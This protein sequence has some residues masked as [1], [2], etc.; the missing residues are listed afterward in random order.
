MAKY[1]KSHSNYRLTQKHQDVNNG[2]ILERDISTIGGVDSF[3]TGQTPIYQSGNFVITVN[4]TITATKHIVKKGWQQNSES[5][6]T[7]NKQI[8]ENYASDVNGSVES[9]IA[10]KNDFADLRS[11]A[12]YGSLY[13]LVETSISDIIQKYPY[14]IYIPKRDISERIT[15]LLDGHS[16]FELSN[17][18]LI[19]FYTENPTNYDDSNELHYLLNGGYKNYEV[20]DSNDNRYDLS[21]LSV[22]SAKLSDIVVS[23]SVDVR[24]NILTLPDSS[25]I[26]NSTYF[27]ITES[28]TTFTSIVWN[29]TKYSVKFYN[30][31][32]NNFKLGGKYFLRYINGSFIVLD[33]MCQE[34]G[35][36]L[37]SV[38]LMYNNGK[39]LINLYA[40]A[41]KNVGVKSYSETYNEELHIRPKE[42]EGFYDEFLDGMNQFQKC[43]L[44]EYSNT[45]FVANFEILTETDSGLRKST[46][47][48][49]LPTDDGGYNIDSS[50]IA[51]ESYVKRLAK[52]ALRYDE[53]FTDNMY[54]LM[55]HESLK[56]F[57]WTRNFNG[58]DN[59]TDN[60]YVD[61][62]EKF[63]SIIRIIGFAF[64]NEKSYID[65][66][67]NVNSISYD[68]R[69]NIPDYFLTDALSLDGWETTTIYPFELKFTD[70]EGN[71]V[72][73]NKDASIGSDERYQWD[74]LQT[75]NTYTRSFYENNQDIIYPYS[76]SE[77]EFYQACVNGKPTLLSVPED[78]DSSEYYVENGSVKNIIKDYS[79]QTEYTIPNINNEFMKRLKM[80]SRYILRKKGTIDSIES[81]LSLFG[82]R[83]K[84]WFGA[85][86]TTRVGEK[87]YS[88][89]YN[90]EDKAP[91][92]FDITE[93][94]AFVEPI[95]ESWDGVHDMYSID[96]YNSQKKIS[97]NTQTYINGEYVSY[98]GLPIAYRDVDDSYIDD[99]NK[100][101]ERRLYPNFDSDSIYDGGMY[102]QMNGGWLDYW[103]YS[104]DVSSTL[105]PNSIGKTN[106]ETYRNVK[107]VKNL[108]ELL[109]QRS[110]VLEDNVVFYVL[111][112][113]T[114]YAVID[115]RIYELAQEVINNNIYYYFKIVVKL[116]GTSIGDYYFNQYIDTK[117]YSGETVTYDLT[118][119]VDGTI[120]KIYY[121][122]NDTEPFYIRGYSEKGWEITVWEGGALKKKR[123]SKGT[124]GAQEVNESETIFSGTKIFI[125]GS[126]NSDKTI[127]TNYFKLVNKD[128]SRRLNSNGWV[129]LTKNN[130]EYIRLNT[131]V[132]NYK[133]N[134][135]HSGCFSYDNGY[136]Y[137]SRFDRLFK[138][139][140]DND[141]INTKC[142]T[143]VD[144]T[145]EEI[146]SIG[147]SGLTSSN[148]YNYFRYLNKDCKVHSF[149]ATMD[150][151]G[152]E[153]KYDLDSSK[154]I[155]R[156]S[157]YDF[158]NQKENAD[159]VTNQI[160]NTKVI[161]IDFYLKGD[162]FYSTEF[163]EQSKYIQDKV[164][165]YV[166]QLIPSTAIVRV[167]L[168]MN[169]FN[170]VYD[171][172]ALNDNNGDEG[173]WH[174]YFYWKDEGI[175]ESGSTKFSNY[176]A[177]AQLL[178]ADIDANKSTYGVSTNTDMAM[179]QY[180]RS[181][182]Y[183]GTTWSIACGTL[184]S[185]FTSYLDT[186]YKDFAIQS[187][188]SLP[189]G[190]VLELPH[191]WAAVNGLYNGFGD[192]CGW[193]GDL[194]EYGAD[195][196]S[197]ST[198]TF[199][200]SSRF[201]KSDW[202][203]DADAY[204]IY[205]SYSSNIVEG[206]KNY[207]TRTLSE[208]YRI[209]S[210]ITEKTIY[211]RYTSS[212]NSIYLSA[213]VIQKGTS[214]TYVKMAAEKMQ[215]YLDNNK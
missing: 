50:S 194:V 35:D 127:A 53:I 213:L 180:I 196:Q 111:D 188:L 176:I 47:R 171:Y 138:Y 169:I 212:K 82:Y 178:R 59:D 155:S 154:F 32:K 208:Q 206:M 100:V 29:K 193:A 60:E 13:S 103:P 204:N 137:I 189:N 201:S 54:R 17:P 44:G 175:W 211:E 75:G 68:N 214:S 86:N 139:A 11:F 181:K 136:E 20:I 105:I 83:S 70:F 147:F 40:F 55:T 87:Y 108:S 161:E 119:C 125:S 110:S 164:M 76:Y 77:G 184:D 63:K 129:Q 174:N 94:T 25:Y 198:I 97:Y 66:I 9:S 36:F 195:L 73:E 101:N 200:N 185:T 187:T 14:E 121:Q 6:D 183:T 46:E 95:K 135:P 146:N 16:L 128:Y 170:W 124:L 205:Q 69:S 166:E 90:I 2:T 114:N 99:D 71:E 92:D 197:D 4:D 85:L 109:S 58:H 88:K 31:D 192:L 162:D 118:Q 207:Y 210:F 156:N 182:A 199:P 149:V 107:Q 130:S 23:K 104:F 27:H 173:I 179:A 28:G 41:D 34:D 132:D 43:L 142:F 190:E 57:D 150:V 10:L 202:I 191:F 21:L 116:F 37:G 12:C 133:G 153:T 168:N 22:N 45:K 15:T 145:M 151:N 51:M 30:K 49:E 209:N 96:F 26:N 24:V 215:E 106:K 186:K 18:A 163:Q 157:D 89:Y 62:G 98:Q 112:L 67:G 78:N 115:G 3:A 113:S 120:I 141:L 152:N 160:I 33:E 38:S 143:V 148:G 167:N 93:Y 140:Y 165:P 39:G 203:A 64:D 172:D 74:E 81:L 80:N 91:Y 61:N 102:Y 158:V 159:G 72:K 144:D 8:L 117:N 79:N 65:T 134:N 7:W 123:V 52:I 131:I 1:T 56:N 84:R 5:G 19:D 177:Q 126:C 122:P 42:S 48:F